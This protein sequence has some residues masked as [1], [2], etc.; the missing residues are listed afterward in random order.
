[1]TCAGL[2]VA[3]AVAAMQSFRNDGDQMKTL[4]LSLAL[5]AAPLAA[6]AATLVID[7]FSTRQVLADR[8]T[9]AFPKSSE[10][11]GPSVIGGYREMAV[12]TLMKRPGPFAT[13]FSSNV[14]GEELLNFS[15]QSGQQGTATLL[16]DGAGSAGLGGIDLTVGGGKG[17]QFLVENAD[18][19]LTIA[20]TVWD[21]AGRQSS[22]EQTFPQTIVGGRISFRFADFGGRADF[23][24]TNAIRFVFSGPPNLD[25][26]VA[27]LAVSPIPVPAGG[28]LLGT[29]LAALSLGASALRRRRKA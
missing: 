22:F 14:D 16:Y 10:A 27:L 19:S 28:L 12:K 6:S 17:F 2:L 21:V 4:F 7:D 20:S 13:T 26:S 1:M 5:A 9:P 11:Y 15:N 18:A 24:S 25:A 29:V 3:D 23:T 8:P